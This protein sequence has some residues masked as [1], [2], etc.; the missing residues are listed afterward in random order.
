MM[1]SFSHQTYPVDLLQQSH[2]HR[3]HLV[4]PAPVQQ[5]QLLQYAYD[6]TLG[7][8]LDLYHR[9]C[10]F[11]ENN[12]SLMSEKIGK[13]QKRLESTD[14]IG[15]DAKREDLELKV[16]KWNEENHRLSEPY[17]LF[18]YSLSTCFGTLKPPT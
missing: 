17:T 4:L 8:N 16:R 10:N 3:T 9:F 13:V 11:I 18:I 6:V 1:F 7:R 14:K 15:F 5:L 2:P 12:R